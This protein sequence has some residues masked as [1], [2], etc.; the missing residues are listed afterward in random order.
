M[1]WIK[2]NLFLVVSSAIALA[3]LGFAGFYLYTKIQQDRA[4]T[5]ELTAATQKLEAL[6]K[7]D[8][9]PNAD[10]IT[11]AKQEVKRVQGFL[12]DIEKHFAPA[13]YPEEL[14]N[15]SF[16]SY[17]DTTRSELIQGAKRAGVEVPTNYWF[18]FSAQKGALNF[19]PASLQPLAAQL[20]DIKALCDVLFDAKVNSLAWLKRV[21]VDSQQDNTMGSQD[22][23]TTKPATNA[24]SVV[25]PYEVAF[26][27][28]SSQL[29]S[30][31]DGLAH[32][33]QCYI[34]TNIVV[35]PAATAGQS[36]DSTAP[37]NRYAP[38]GGMSMDAG[39]RLRARY[40]IRA[41][42]P[43]PVVAVR[44]GPTTFLEEKPLRIILSVQAV[45]LKPRTAPAAAPAAARATRPAAAPAPQPQPTE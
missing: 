39:A 24:W 22:Y 15:M 6:A 9:Y 5:E 41:P 1:Q 21:P 25:M 30:V 13:P 11:A 34:V 44:R 26:Q 16:R 8:P 42:A 10:N 35:E 3:L 19:N 40:G 33:P 17:L 2:R 31:L 32:L 38:S 7:R 43:P 27:G 20:A 37:E 23:V 45:R 28:F 4:K 18:T 29:A 12:D 14:N 36:T